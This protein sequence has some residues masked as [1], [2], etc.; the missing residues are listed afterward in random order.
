MFEPSVD[1]A[2][3]MASAVCK[4]TTGSRYSV[5]GGQRISIAKQRQSVVA[6]S[7]IAFHPHES[8][9]VSYATLGSQGFS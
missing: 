3:Q 5:F 2:M 7:Q 4:C 9:L 8:G 6:R 1:Y